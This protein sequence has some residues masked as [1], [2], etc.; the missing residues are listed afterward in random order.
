MALT[1]LNYTG[2]GTIPI[3]SIPTLTGAKMPTGSVIQTVQGG[4][5]TRFLSTSGT[6]FVDCGVSVNITPSSTS[7]TI[8]ITVS[9]ALASESSSGQ[10]CR[11]K[12]F[13][14]STEIGSGT[15]GSSYNDFVMA[16]PTNPYNMY[17]FSNSHIDSPSTTSQITYKIQ[18]AAGSTPDVILGGRGESYEIAVPT[19]ITVMEI[20]G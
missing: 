13:R 11:L 9:G 19:R 7:S 20:A 8:L 17:S 6:T 16:L 14:G 2:Q 12:L 18:V 4:R 10:R 3:A 15:G 5:T 1:K